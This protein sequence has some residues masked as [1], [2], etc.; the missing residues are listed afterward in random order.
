MLLT[1]SVAKN[2]TIIEISRIKMHFLATSL[3]KYVTFADF[4]KNNYGLSQAILTKIR[5]LKYMEKSVNFVDFWQRNRICTQTITHT[6][7]K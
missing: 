4:R 3:E 2:H 5:H 1:K 6:Q 7:K